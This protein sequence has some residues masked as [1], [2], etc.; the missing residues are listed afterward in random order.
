[1]HCKV[2]NRATGRPRPVEETCFAGISNIGKE[3]VAF[4]RS[5][6]GL[7]VTLIGCSVDGGAWEALL[8]RAQVGIGD[9]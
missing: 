5:R 1:M 3:P 2:H 4:K 8:K 6:Y 9:E 7:E